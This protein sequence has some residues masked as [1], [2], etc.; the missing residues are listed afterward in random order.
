MRRKALLIASC[1]LCLAGC[2]PPPPAQPATTPPAAADAQPA[3]T[4]DTAE[5]SQSVNETEEPEVSQENLPAAED[6]LTKAVEALGGREKIDSVESF[7]AEA[8]TVIPQQNIT[9][10]AK[11]WWKDG[12]SYVEQEMPQVG[13][14]KVWTTPE[15][16]WSED[17]INGLR[18]L[19]GKELAQA[20]WGESLVLVADWEKHFDAAQTK[21]RRKKD[22]KTLIDVELT[23]ESGSSLKIAFDEDT[24]L[25]LE[26]SFVQVS[27]N[28][29]MP[30]TVYIEEYEEVDGLKR[31]KK[32]VTD[33]TL[34][35]ATTTMKSFEAGAKVPDKKLQPPKG[36]TK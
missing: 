27:P 4:D 15:G 12:R 21:G 14:F 36:K 31:E 19:E 10:V 17:P 35:K 33:M 28:G 7:Y 16:V 5:A 23:S 1:V 29:N 26:Q 30:L 24:G 25:P 11:T 34:L 13:V 8:E 20:R 22:D 32:T 6:V 9:S 2:Q 18:K 3:Q